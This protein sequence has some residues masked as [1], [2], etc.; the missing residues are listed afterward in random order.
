MLLL[1]SDSMLMT[2]KHCLCPESR[3]LH[4]VAKLEV[5]PEPLTCRHDPAGAMFAPCGNGLAGPALHFLVLRTS[6]VSPPAAFGRSLF[7]LV[8]GQFLGSAL[9]GCATPSPQMF[10]GSPCP[11]PAARTPGSPPPTVTRALCW[12]IWGPACGSLRLPP[13]MVWV[14]GAATALPRKQPLPLGGAWELPGGGWP[15]WLGPR[16]GRGQPAGPQATGFGSVLCKLVLMQVPR[17]GAGRVGD[18]L[19]QGRVTVTHGAVAGKTR[20]WPRSGGLC[21]QTEPTTVIQFC[22]GLAEGTVISLLCG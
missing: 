7:P 14:P 9:E 3:D 18:R 21:F 6:W 17:C 10:T 1:C 22:V 4:C 12:P 2:P 13:E 19:V 20:R 8:I 5:Q 15:S 16:G 11:V